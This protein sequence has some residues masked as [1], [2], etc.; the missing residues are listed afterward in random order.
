VGMV[1]AYDGQASLRMSD[2]GIPVYPRTVTIVNDELGADFM[3]FMGTKDVCLLKGH[4]MTTAGK[5][6][7]EATSNS[8]TLFRFARMNYLG[9]AIGGPREVPDI[10]EHRAR[11][12][13]ERP[14]WGGRKGT[15]TEPSGWRH[16]RRRLEE[17]FND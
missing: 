1:G 14:R 12:T 9:Q 10:E 3:E 4:G 2:T 5:T 13:D 15:S 16:E 7:E 11:W 17:Y 8:L 6:V